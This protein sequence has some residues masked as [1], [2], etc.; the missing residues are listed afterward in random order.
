MHTETQ[1]WI[2]WLKVACFVT[3]ATGVVSAAASTEALQGPWLFLF[4]LIRWPLDDN[5]AAFVDGTHFM[6]GVAGGLMA[7]WGLL[8]Y[9]IVTGPFARGDY[10]L[11]MPIILSMALWFVL[12]SFGSV[13]SGLPGNLI[14]NLGFVGLFLP[15]LLALRQQAPSSS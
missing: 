8:M 2:T 5:P 14:L 1:K 15:P 10:E 7:G 6:N 9:Y 4:D 13:S 12:D 11:T 3:I